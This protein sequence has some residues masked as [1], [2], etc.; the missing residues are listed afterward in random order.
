MKFKNI[1]KNKKIIITIITLLIISS[2][3]LVFKKEEK[4][5]FIDINEILQSEYYANLPESAKAYIKQRF[6]E[7]GVV[8]KVEGNKEKNEPYLNPDYIEYLENDDV[9]YE[10][11][12]NDTIIDYIYNEEA[13]TATALPSKF[14]LRSYN[15]NN[16]ITPLKNQGSEGLCWAYAT[17]EH[18]ESKIMLHENRAYDSNTKIISAK[19][20]DYATA[21]DGINDYILLNNIF[22]NPRVLKSGGNFDYAA[23]LLVRNLGSVPISWEQSVDLTKPSLEYDEIFSYNYSLY[24]INSTID[25]PNIDFES[26]NYDDPE[27]KAI[28]DSYLNKVKENIM[29]N[30]GAVITGRLGY[31][32]GCVT[33]NSNGDSFVYNYSYC[34]NTGAH[35]EQIIGWDD[36]FEYKLCKANTT[37]NTI[38][39][40]PNSSN[41]V[42]GSQVTGKGAW[43]MRNS[44]GNNYPYYYIPYLSSNYYINNIVDIQE[45]D[46]DN[47]YTFRAEYEYSSTTGYQ[48][49]FFATDKLD[50]DQKLNKIKINLDNQNT[51]YTFYLGSDKST[52][53]KLKELTTELPGYYT[54]DL[55]DQ[56]I[57]LDAPTYYLKIDAEDVNPSNLLYSFT[58]LYMFTDDV[59]SSTSIKV[60]DYTHPALRKKDDYYYIRAL[61]FTEGIDDGSIVTFRVLDNNNNVIN[62]VSYSDN[63]VYANYL[64]ANIAIPV[65]V[66]ISKEYKLETY[67]N[68]ELKY[69]SKITFEEGSDIIGDGTIDNPYQITKPYE[70]DLIRTSP[71]S[72]YI[73]TNDIDLTYDTTNRNGL[74]YNDGHGWISIENFSGG[75]DGNNHTIKGLHST[76][77]VFLTQST[78]YGGLFNK[79]D[80]TKY[81]TAKKVYIK[82]LKMTDVDL[83]VD[84]VLVNN[85]TLNNNIYKGGYGVGAVVNS[86]VYKTPTDSTYKNATFE[87][88]N[89]SVINGEIQNNTGCTSH[90]SSSYR[91]YNNLGGVIGYIDYES[92]KYY[93]ED[94]DDKNGNIF[95][96]HLNI[97]NIYNGANIT[98]IYGAS[99]GIIGHIHYAS[100]YAPNY[101]RNIENYGLIDGYKYAGGIIGTVTGFDLARNTY[102][103]LEN[104]INYGEVESENTSAD[105][106]NEHELVS[107]TTY[108]CYTCDKTLKLK[109]VYYTGYNDNN[110]SMFMISASDY[111]NVNNYDALEM[112]DAN[113]SNWDNFSTYWTNESNDN[114]KRI[115]VL[116]NSNFEYLNVLT[117]KII[118]D[119]ND[120]KSIYDYVTP[121]NEL[122]EALVF[123]DVDN[124]NIVEIDN[125]GIIRPKN[126]GTTTI[127]IISYYDGYQ[128]TIEIQVLDD[129]IECA[130]G[131]YLP[132]NSNSCIT[133]PA[134]S[135]C[136]GGYYIKS[137]TEQGRNLCSSLANGS[138]T[139]SASGSSESSSCYIPK[140]NLNGKYVNEAYEE[141]ITCSAGGYCSGNTDIYYGN[142]G[143]RT[144]CGDGKYNANTGSS[145]SNSCLDIMPGCYGTSATTACP[146]ECQGKTKYSAAGAKQCSTVALGY[147]T[148]GCNESN[149]KC[150][151]QRICPEGKYCVNGTA[152]YCTVGS[153]TNLTGQ[154]S[155]NVCS[156]GKTTTS[157]GTTS[158]DM[159]C[160]NSEGVTSW[161]QASWINNTINNLCKINTCDDYYL[162]DETNNICS[163]K[164]I[165][166]I[167]KANGGIGTMS[168]QT[169]SKD[170]LLTQ[171]T[172]TKEGNIFIHWNT[173]NDDTGT[174]F[175]DKANLNEYIKNQT[176]N[177]TL[178]LYAIFGES[179][180]QIDGEYVKNIK[181]KTSVTDFVNGMEKDSDEVVKVYDN[182]DQELA[183]N[184]LIY[185]GSI[186]KI[187]KNNNLVASYINIV[188]GDVNRD[189]NVDIS[190]VS[191]LYSKVMGNNIIDD[192]IEIAGD[193]NKDNHIDI[194]DV[195]KIYNFYFY[196]KQL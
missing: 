113:Y 94:T 11:V 23:R 42:A 189:G 153:F 58:D 10:V 130:K 104:I 89:V 141:P 116:K 41:C 180:Y 93:N 72:Y 195:S 125:D 7:T 171:N 31:Q 61:G 110:T 154:T 46:W 190:D 126:N 100:K 155:C 107:D 144:E 112:V 17:A 57:I 194:S 178:E 133:C 26:M 44:W 5:D 122:V 186:T 135:Y 75:F 124:E 191:K 14:D 9:T 12:P 162:K 160:T 183:P 70:L 192:L 169:L 166:V 157:E 148:F 66:D 86:V 131:K 74:F 8:L 120:T 105:I 118:I 29:N 36:D 132:A 163:K 117:N 51:K 172:Y 60:E 96:E 55:S 77:E 170:D 101:I 173:K 175:E 87:I 64:F 127:D 174:S 139:K 98:S 179:L 129:S 59:D 80:M 99:G 21:K 49:I 35:A 78:N 81:T 161:L 43:L 97:D 38:I 138:Y 128:N 177:N 73:L 45:K 184:R 84:N 168:N 147:E 65:G 102:L 79:I 165:T 69:R 142:N 13:A 83:T 115:A 182:N 62:N 50:T 28:I 53:I 68:N 176:T 140:L 108:S 33:T 156:N 92:S 137:D 48:N 106:F 22:Y 91:C 18:L 181:K 188:L 109:N 152:S 158:C 76:G 19:Y 2:S 25:Y 3:F 111:Q 121:N 95:P 123:F 54:I 88:S 150:S 1:L 39:N 27:D 103:Y 164:Q 136:E 185:T 146:N 167:F 24:D 149:N 193:V 37:S 82:N 47:Y 119:S 151:G 15:G 143:G 67:Y 134:N 40:N 6:E 16:Y 63:K 56:N 4:K 32:S 145:S 30:G 90:Y 114:I 159:D 71:D 52:L 85:S 196:N 187:F 34:T 20:Y